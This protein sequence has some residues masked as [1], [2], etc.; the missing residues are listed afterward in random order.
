MRINVDPVKPLKPDV[1]FIDD[2]R[3]EWRTGLGTAK[4]AMT[5]MIQKPLA[6]YAGQ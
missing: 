2:A 1:L 3:N 5:E 4:A 6:D